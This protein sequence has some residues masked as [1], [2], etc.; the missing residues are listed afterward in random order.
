MRTV[1]RN[2][3]QL[4]V[5]AVM[6]LT[7]LL[8]ACSRDATSPETQIRELIAQAQIAA[9]ARDA[10]SLRALIADDYADDQGNNRKAME[11]LIRLHI[12][13]NQSIHLFTRIR[14]IAF[15]QP[16]RA[17]VRVAAAM[18]GRPV[19]SASELA[20]MNADLYRFDLELVR[21]GGSWRVQRA[22]WEP[23]GLDDFL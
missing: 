18:A 14:D 7:L 6:T 17:T 2:R 13:R 15:L 21:R 10:A 23:A 5:W 8:I 1:I 9:E 12:L 11:S 19:V 16:D 22:V 3:P 20:G 4:P